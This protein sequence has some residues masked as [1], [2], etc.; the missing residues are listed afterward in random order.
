M[1]SRPG[2]KTELKWNRDFLS[3]ESPYGLTKAGARAGGGFG[4][5]LG[6]ITHLRDIETGPGF[7][8]VE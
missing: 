1:R 7:V 3:N 5:S 6:L 8:F 2:S 4:Y